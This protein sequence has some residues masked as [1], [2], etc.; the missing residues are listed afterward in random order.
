MNFLDA[1]IARHLL[2]GSA[3]RCVLSLAATLVTE[4]VWLFLCPRLLGNNKAQLLYL[5]TEVINT[6][7]TCWLLQQ[8]RLGSCN[9]MHLEGLANLPLILRI[10]QAVLRHIGLFLL[11]VKQYQLQYHEI[12]FQCFT[13]ET[14]PYLFVETKLSRLL[15]GRNLCSLYQRSVP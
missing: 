13:H 7:K 14:E 2:F 5:L 1:T 12:S 9:N 6:C 4:W 3:M 11:S 8:Y 15:S 10:F